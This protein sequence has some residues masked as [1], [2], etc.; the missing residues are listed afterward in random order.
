MDVGQIA[1][2]IMRVGGTRLVAATGVL[3]LTPLVARLYDPESFGF[4]STVLALGLLASSCLTLGLDRA[5]IAANTSRTALSVCLTSGLI[6]TSLLAFIAS[7][8]GILITASNISGDNQ[9]LWPFFF[10]VIFIAFL[11]GIQ[12]LTGPLVLR[13]GKHESVALSDAVQQ[14]LTSVLRIAGGLVGAANASLL[15][16]SHVVGTISQLAIRIRALCH[17]YHKF[18]AV[19]CAIPKISLRVLKRSRG[20]IAYRLPAKMFNSA[21]L[22][23]PVVMVAIFY[24]P[25]QAGAFAMVYRITNL[26]TNLYAQSTIEVLLSK[27]GYANRQMAA[28]QLLDKRIILAHVILSALTYVGF[29][30]MAPT[31]VLALLGRSWVLAANLADSFSGYAA[32]TVLAACFYPYLERTGSN[33]TQFYLHLTLLGSRVVPFCAPEKLFDGLESRIELMSSLVLLTIA[34]FM[35]VTAKKRSC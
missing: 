14:V 3:L 9:S 35:F 2:A 29:E 20:Y 30:F 21:G 7:I 13:I 28:A 22:H 1:V 5:I 10:S 32:G 27:A 8:G 33:R 34:L 12:E 24:A 4:A 6:S 19:V 11:G 17:E 31:L 16:L 26:V 18:S 15:V 23:V 25:F